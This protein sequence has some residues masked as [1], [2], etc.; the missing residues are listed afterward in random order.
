MNTTVTKADTIERNWRL[1]DAKGQI[2]GRMSTEIATLLMGKDK[3]YYTPALDCGDYIVV[4]NAQA[5]EVTGAK[6]TDKIYRHHT[7]HPGGFREQTFA[8]VQ[9]KDPK[10]II[11][12][13]V[14]GMLPKN[15]LRDPR[16]K[17]LKIFSG[18]EHPYADKFKPSSK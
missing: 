11:S 5:V 15:K 9:A 7:G 10:V 3:A 4:I 8:Q 17:R 14:K 18:S 1:I 16:L 12:Q 13:S 2:L 6:K